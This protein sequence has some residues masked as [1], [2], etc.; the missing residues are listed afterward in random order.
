LEVINFFKENN[1]APMIYFIG[2]CKYYSDSQS[3]FVLTGVEDQHLKDTLLRLPIFI[4]G[5]VYSLDFTDN[6]ILAK[7]F[8]ER[9]GNI[10]ISRG[11]ENF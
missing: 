2:D 10:I 1:T 4:N 6:C 11:L 5:S 8:I 7:K 3:C 9:F